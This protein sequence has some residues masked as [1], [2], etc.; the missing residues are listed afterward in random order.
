MKKI[1]LCGA[2]MLA[3][4]TIQDS[5][6]ADS[7]YYLNFS[8]GIAATRNSDVSESTV[9]LTAEADF[10]N[11]ALF[12]VAAGWRITNQF[13][14]EIEIGYNKSDFDLDVSGVKFD[15]SSKTLTGLINGYYDFKTGSRFSPYIG[16]GIGIARHDADLTTA[17]VSSSDKDTVLAYQAGAGALIEISPDWDIQAGYRYLGT[18]DPD[19]GTFTSEY[20]AHQLRVGAIYNF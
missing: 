10:D 4:A 1:L 13:R 6:A 20:H 11:S 12:S 7:D 15:G 17:T 18:S 3:C 14:S 2:S 19:F 5:A 8:T 9:P 16:A